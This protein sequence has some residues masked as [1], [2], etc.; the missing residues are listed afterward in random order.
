ME[1]KE[2]TKKRFTFSNL[3][4]NTYEEESVSL[5][6]FSGFLLTIVPLILMTICII[7]YF[8]NVEEANNV[9]TIINSMVTVLGIGSGVMVG[10]KISSDFGP[11]NRIII[12]GRNELKKQK[13][14]SVDSED[15]SEEG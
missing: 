2:K 6:G 14:K 10:R 12:E 7:F 11:N 5:T 13:Q 15:L 4:S 3:I 8:F 9:I 1:P